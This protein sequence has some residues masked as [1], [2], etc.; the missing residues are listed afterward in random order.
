MYAT[1]GFCSGCGRTALLLPI[2]KDK[3]LICARCSSNEPVKELLERMAQFIE[4]LSPPKIEPEDPSEICPDCGEVHVT[5]ELLDKRLTRAFHAIES[6]E[7]AGVCTLCK[8]EQTCLPFGAEW[9]LV[10]KGC[11]EKNLHLVDQ[12]F[13]RVASKVLKDLHLENGISVASVA[14]P[15][16]ASKED[17]LQA[18]ADMNA[19]AH[20]KDR[21][22]N[23]VLEDMARESFENFAN[24]LLQNK[25]VH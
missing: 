21:L 17:A 23:A 4:S 6:Q 22:K 13:N 10:C 14:I 12:T 20:I 3:A 9:A 8:K 1:H 7:T 16:D 5:Q 11:I 19:P 2:G 24:S 15:T 18:V 25:T